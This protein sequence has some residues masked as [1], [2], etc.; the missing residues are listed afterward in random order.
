MSAYPLHGLAQH[1]AWGGRRFIPRLLNWP[2]EDAERVAE[3]WL[4]AHED[5]PSVIMTAHGP[6]PLHYAIAHQPERFLGS[7]VRGRHGDRL[8]F[9]LKVLDVEAP[10]SIQAHPDA[11]QA[12]AGFA[13]DN[14]AGLA[15]HDRRRH[16]RDPFPKPEMMV[17]LSPFWL[18][19]GMRADAE[20]DALLARQPEWAPLRQRLAEEGGAGLYRH[21]LRLP[22]PEVA[23]L[24]AP[25]WQRLARQ[26]AVGPDDPDHWAA[27]LADARREDRGVFGCYL[28]NLVGLRPG[29][30][31][32]QPARLPH[33]YL[34]GRNVELMANSDNVLRAGLTEKPVDV[35]ALLEVMEGAAARPRVMSAPDGCG[36]QPYPRCG[37]EYFALDQLLLGEGEAASWLAEGPEVLL[38]VDGSLQ[39]RHAEGEIE[40]AQG[41][42]A[43]LLPGAR[44]EAKAG[45]LAL[46]YRAFCP[47][48]AL[49]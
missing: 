15:A 4:G 26:P 18:L 49:C 31:I 29:E 7:A 25:L 36:L 46:A 33:A 14:A 37:G 19:H 16:Y 27:R 43:L 39:V 40:L 11:E 45:R 35:E 9:L 38:V 1:Y 32:F 20:I 34:H 22:Q 12:R 30:A 5:A 10:L 28:L 42:S 13:R 2:V 41:Q 3:W 47:P 21:L 8:P 6:Q 44:C 24:L 17:A 48:A 23:A